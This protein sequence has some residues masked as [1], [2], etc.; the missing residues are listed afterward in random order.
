MLVNY[1]GPQHDK[2]SHYYW[3]EIDFNQLLSSG[4]NP[5]LLA[6]RRPFR[7]VSKIAL[8]VPASDQF[9]DSLRTPVGDMYGGFVQANALETILHRNPILPAGNTANDMILLLVGMATTIAASRLSPWRSVGAVALVAVLFAT[10]CVG[11]FDF[12]GIWIHMASAEATIA[13]VFTGIV[14][15]RARAEVARHED[16]ARYALQLAGDLQH[17]REQLVSLREEERRRLRRDLHDGLGPAL[18]SIL[19]KVSAARRVLGPRSR[20]DAILLEARGD[21]QTTI[22]DIRRLVYDLRP[23]TL[24]ELGLTGAIREGAAGYEQDGLLIVVQAPEH[25][26]L[27]PAAVEVA[28]YRIVQEALTNVVRHA[29]ARTCTVALTIRDGLGVDVSDDGIGMPALRHVGVGLTSM[30]ERAAE[31]GGTCVTESAA[32]GG[33]RVR[34]R[35]PL[36]KE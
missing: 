2:S 5:R 11:L 21:I 12:M 13:L 15:V 20:G 31:L 26:P 22:E 27:L 4:G 6:D 34:A 14:A 8:I 25:L 36:P 10:I 33:T 3:N 28:A 30:G 1:I 29:A 17:A 18:S 7:L 24:D 9:N 16:D 23:P 35:L 32:G 19:L